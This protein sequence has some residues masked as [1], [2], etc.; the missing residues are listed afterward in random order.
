M[1]SVTKRTVLPERPLNHGHHVTARQLG[2]WMSDPRTEWVGDCHGHGEALQ[3]LF[4]LLVLALLPHRRPSLLCLPCRP[5]ERRTGILRTDLPGSD[6]SGSSD[7]PT[8]VS[9]TAGPDGRLHGDAVHPAPRPCP[10]EDT[11]TSAFKNA[12][13]AGAIAA[14][15]RS[16]AA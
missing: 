9:S 11:S 10:P 5:E 7:Q 2:W 14:A 8:D 13:H 6:H 15:A 16:W 3:D 1:V 4:L 12:G